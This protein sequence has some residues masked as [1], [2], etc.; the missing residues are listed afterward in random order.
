MAALV[1]S[2]ASRARRLGIFLAGLVCVAVGVACMI[3]AELGVAPYDV[4]TTGLHERFGIPM[5]LAAVLLP[6]VFLAAG[7]ALGGRLGVG[8]L[9]A[10]V[11]VGPML[12]VALDVLP[13][14]DA[15]APRLVLYAGGFVVLVVGV[16]LVIVPELG[17][18]PAEL[19]MLAIHQRGLALV[20]VRTG[21]ELACVAAG[22]ALGGQVGAGTVVFALLV[23]PALGQ[24]LDRLGYAT[25][26]AA[27]VAGSPGIGG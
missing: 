9:L 16:A 4:L 27:E 26:P 5:A 15:M 18:G 19:L 13:D 12:G 11:L 10:V 24:A 25:R 20:P 8:S 6:M 17:A 14:L 22:W 21:I 23:G 3:R 1:P 2:D 7:A